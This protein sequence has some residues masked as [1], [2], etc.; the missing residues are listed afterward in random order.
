CRGFVAAGG[1]GPQ[2]LDRG[3][4]CRRLRASRVLLVGMKGLGAEVAKNLILAGVK[5]LT[6]LDHQQVS[7]EDTRAQFLIPGGSLG[8]NRAEAS[9][10]R[11]QNLNPMVDVKADAG[12]VDTKPEEFFTQFDARLV[13]CPLKEALSVDWSGEKAAAALKRTAPDY[14]LLQGKLLLPVPCS[15]F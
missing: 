8:R 14:F 7:Q 6:M 12:N 2:A 10:E 3:S 9:L 4:L 1:G 15:P 11:A 13:F 5:G